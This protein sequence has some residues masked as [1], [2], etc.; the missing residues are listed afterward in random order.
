MIAG[1]LCDRQGV[2]LAAIAD[3]TAN[4]TDDNCIEAGNKLKSF[5][6]YFQATAA[7]DSNDQATAAFYNGEAAMLGSGFLG[8]RTDQRQT[9]QTS[10]PNVVSSSSLES[11][12]LTTRTV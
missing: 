11:T 9:I 2:D 7:G 5:P 3:H 8:N 1:Y 4:W 12:V 10:S 6:S